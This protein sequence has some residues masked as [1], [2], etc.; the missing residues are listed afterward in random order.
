MAILLF[1]LSLGA[2][3]LTL[4]MLAISRSAIHEAVAAALFVATAVLFVGSA[5][6]GAINARAE[7]I[8]KRLPPPR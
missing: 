6:V 3:F 5:I 1:L 8:L 2:G 7:E 4:S